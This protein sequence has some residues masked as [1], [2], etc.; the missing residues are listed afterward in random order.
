MPKSTAKYQHSVHLW[1][2]QKKKDPRQGKPAE[3]LGESSGAQKTPLRWL[4]KKTRA[5]AEVGDEGQMQILN[6][7]YS[8]RDWTKVTPQ[9]K[10]TAEG[11][12]GMKRGE[13]RTPP[14]NDFI[15]GWIWT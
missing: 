15:L 12:V 2:L 1:V 5:N 7:P 3:G 11:S 4:Y 13:F 6:K 10:S 8:R 9:L 14:Q